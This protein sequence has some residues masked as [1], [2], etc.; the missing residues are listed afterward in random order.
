MLTTVMAWALIS[1]AMII[2]RGFLSFLLFSGFNK[3]LNKYETQETAVARCEKCKFYVDFKHSDRHGLNT[4]TGKK[5]YSPKMFL[6]S[7]QCVNKF[8]PALEHN[9]SSEWQQSPA[10]GPWLLKHSSS[11]IWCWAAVAGLPP[12][13]TGQKTQ[14]SGK[15]PDPC[16]VCSRNKQHW[17]LMTIPA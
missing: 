16:T 10:A 12:F 2:N 17:K 11:V 13:H 15:V 7:L 1:T 3:C 8:L 5:R 4:F 6:V 14:S 9:Q